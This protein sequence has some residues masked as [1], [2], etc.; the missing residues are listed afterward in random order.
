MSLS[1]D[2]VSRISFLFNCGLIGC[3]YYIF[4]RRSWYQ[5]KKFTIPLSLL[6]TVFIVAAVL[7]LLLV[8]RSGM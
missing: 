1:E 4:S 2:R 3:F 5:K 6:V 7:G 8:L